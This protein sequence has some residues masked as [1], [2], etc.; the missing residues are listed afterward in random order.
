MVDTAD[1]KSADCKVMPVRV[2]PLV[3]TINK[4]FMG[5]S[6]E[7]FSFFVK[8]TAILAMDLATLLPSPTVQALSGD[9]ATFEEKFRG[10]VPFAA[11]FPETVAAPCGWFLFPD[12]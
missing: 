7:A 4:G 10:L 11:G 8:C 9:T 1:S 6:R 12:V 3:P 2:R 5:I